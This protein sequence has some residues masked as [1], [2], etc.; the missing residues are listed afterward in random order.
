MENFLLVFNVVFLIFF[1]MILGVILKR[2]SMVDEKF[3]NVMNFLIFRLFM[4]ILLF[5]NI[6][7]MGDLLIFLFDNLKLLV[8]VFISIFIVFFFVWL[9]YMFNIKD[10]KKL[11]VLI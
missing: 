9:I 3:L 4:F 10:R 11:L 7:N 5:F 8:Y 6:Y 1:I 2:K